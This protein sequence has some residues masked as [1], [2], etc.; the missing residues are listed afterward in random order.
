MLLTQGTCNVQAE[1]AALQ[2]VN[3]HWAAGLPGTVTAAR[4]MHGAG[5]KHLVWK[6]TCTEAYCTLYT[7]ESGKDRPYSPLSMVLLSTGLDFVSPQS[8]GAYAG[9]S[10]QSRASGPPLERAERGSWG[11]THLTTHPLSTGSPSLRE[12]ERQKKPKHTA[13]N[14]ILVN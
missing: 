6:H 13:N 3:V 5:C 10:Y 2:L 4:R 7:T 11:P 1:L 14:H 8:L 9:T 12:K